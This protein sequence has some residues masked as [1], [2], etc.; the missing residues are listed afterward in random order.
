MYIKSL[1]YKAKLV[2]VLRNIYML[3]THFLYVNLTSMSEQN[4]YIKFVFYEDK[5]KTLYI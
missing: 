1:N 4:Y 3:F 5:V 2:V